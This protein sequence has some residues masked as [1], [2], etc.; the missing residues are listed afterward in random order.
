MVLQ[1][2]KKITEF[3]IK[4]ENHKIEQTNSYKYLGIV[5]DNKLSWQKHVI[6][7]ANKISRICGLFFKLR[8]L[9]NL[10][11]LLTLYYG[12]I[13]PHLHYGITS[14]GTANK[15]VIQ[16]LQ[17]IQNRLIKC[18][19]FAKLKDLLSPKYKETK[20]LKIKDIYQLEVGKFMFKYKSQN[21]P[22]NFESYFFNLS[23]IH[24]HNTRLNKKDNKYLPRVRTCLGQKKLHF[25][26]VQIWNN[27][28]PLIQNIQS[29]PSFSKKFKENLIENY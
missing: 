1:N 7:L 8:H 22:E 3:S 18:I 14:W 2:T 25:A 6:Y 10:D 17:V 4:I 27:L 21:L 5:L 9:V 28:P 12:L 11:I 19:T 16:P 13:Y 23:N 26:G 24:S 29:L 15:T 20:I